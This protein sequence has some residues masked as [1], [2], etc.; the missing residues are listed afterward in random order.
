MP[1]LKDTESPLQNEVGPLGAIWGVGIG[2]I[3]RS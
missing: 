2:L 1:A 3:V